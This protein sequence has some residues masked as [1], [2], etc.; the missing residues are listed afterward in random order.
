MT[1][2]FL[3][4]L[5]PTSSARDGDVKTVLPNPVKSQPPPSSFWSSVHYILLFFFVSGDLPLP[6]E[7]PGCSIYCLRRFLSGKRGGRSPFLSPPYFLTFLL[8]E[9]VPRFFPDLSYG[10]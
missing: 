1:N 7:G 3:S 8:K 9:F 10:S 6:P 5:L 4:E 2:P